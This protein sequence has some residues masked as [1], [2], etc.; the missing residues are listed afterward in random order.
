MKLLLTSA[1]ITNNS[2]KD[3]LFNLV[4]KTPNETNI[5]YIPTASN[6]EEGHKDW[7][8]EDLQNIYN[9]NLKTFD[10]VDI[11]GLPKEKWFPRLEQ[12]DVLVFGGGNTFHLMHWVVKSGLAKILPDLLNTKVYVGISAGSMI[13]N[14]MVETPLQALFESEP[15]EYNIKEGLKY[16]N[17]YTI[18]HYQS[19]WFKN[20]TKENIKEKSKDIEV[21]VYALDDN[22]SLV[23]EGDNI[24]FV[25]EGNWDK[26]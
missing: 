24:N 26:F 11:S 17:L 22:P 18:P 9:L 4:G 1:G 23:I 15:N 8:I 16:V 19:E 3:T 12:A 25:S 14:P 10:I 13:T 6:V 7:L 2:I 21:T 20:L 5:V